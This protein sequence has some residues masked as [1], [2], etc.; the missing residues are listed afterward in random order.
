MTDNRTIGGGGVGGYNINWDEIDENTNPF[1]LG[2]AFRGNK[3][4]SSPPITSA[5]PG[6]A[7]ESA[8][9]SHPDLSVYPPESVEEGNSN[10][11]PEVVEASNSV[12]KN[13]KSET[14]KIKQNTRGLRPTPPVR[15]VSNTNSVD[16]SN[17]NVSGD[18]AQSAET[19]VS[20]NA[21]IPP[22]SNFSAKELVE[23]QFTHEGRSR[24]NSNSSAATFDLA[25]GNPSLLPEVESDVPL[26]VDEELASLRAD[27]EHLTTIVADMQ[28]CIAEYER[29]LRQL[30]EEKAR[31]E[32]SAKESVIDIIS[33][34]DQAVEEISTI[35][36]AF[37]DLH[38]RF[39]KSKQIIEGFKSNEE[40]L[41]RA[42][43]EYQDQL[44]RQEQR[45]QA[46]KVH[47]EQQL[48]KIAEETERAKR[49]N[50]DE[51]TR[52]RAA[53]KRSELRIHSLESQLEQKVRENTELTKI[54]DELLKLADEVE[55]R[56]APIDYVTSFEGCAS[57]CK[58][59]RHEKE[60]VIPLRIA[61]P[62]TLNLLHRKTIGRDNSADMSVGTLNSSS[63]A[64]S[65]AEDNEIS[66]A[67]A[68]VDPDYNQVPVEGFG[69]ALLKGM[70]L[71]EGDIKQRTSE[72]FAAKLRLKGL[73]LGADHR[74][75]LKSRQKTEVDSEKL[76]WKVGAKCQI[77]YGRNEGR[78]GVIKG[79][80][81][82]IG[83]IMVELAATKQIVNVMQ[84]T[85]RLVSSSEFE[86]F[87][88]YLNMAGAKQ[89]NVDEIANANRIK[90][91]G[92]VAVKPC[93][94]KR[95]KEDQSNR[96]SQSTWLRKG[97]IVRYLNKRSKY[98]LR[99]IKVL[100]VSASQSHSYQC[101]C[102][103]E[104]GRTLQNIYES[105]LKPT[106]PKHLGETV[107]V[108]RGQYLGKT[109]S[110]IERNDRSL[111]ARISLHATAE[112][113]S[114]HYAGLV[115]G[116][117]VVGIPWSPSIGLIESPRWAA[118][119]L[120]SISSFSHEHIE[121]FADPSGEVI[122][123]RQRDG[124]FVPS[125]KLL[126]K[127]PFLLPQ[128][129]IDRGAIKHV[130][131]GSNIMCPGLTSPGAKLCDVPANTVV[132]IMAEGKEH[133]VAVGVT[134]MSTNEMLDVNKNIGLTFSRMSNGSKACYS[135]CSL[136]PFKKYGLPVL[137]ASILI[138]TAWKIIQPDYKCANKTSYLNRKGVP[139]TFYIVNQ[140]DDY[141][142]NRGSLLNVGVRESEIM[143]SQHFESS[144]SERTQPQPA[145]S[146]LALHDVDLL[147]TD[148]DLRYIGGAIIIS[149]ESYKLINGFSNR[150]W[151]WGQEDDEFGLRIREANL[152]IQSERKPMVIT[153][154]FQHL[155]SA[156]YKR[157][158]GPYDAQMAY[159]RDHTSGLNTTQ[160][161]VLSR[162]SA[163]ISNVSAWILNVQLY[164]DT[165]TTPYCRR[166]A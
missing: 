156:T 145:C 159:L 139:H 78:Y 50:E 81:G 37:G 114:L 155:H 151:G 7:H 12:S 121:L 157:E 77:V 9:S 25:S 111:R 102:E 118:L 20:D 41:K 27:K 137:A 38:R 136:R 52:L 19:H 116:D 79:M 63:L 131:N 61:R 110:L 40:A 119:Y 32:E 142:F 2:A 3:L 166:D 99:K 13:T 123:F 91:Q 141:R 56:E 97:L 60:L 45:Y 148:E 165:L 129:Q 65:T 8:E 53:I 105:D 90:C 124:P 162:V 140:A 54:C 29:S 100:S 93:S 36:K 128:L 16:A 49:A 42:A 34:R 47:A 46:L 113:I 84:A 94:P 85:V 103:T 126:H 122:F 160:Y 70:G 24:R 76:L 80:D 98:Y 107:V 154:K 143:E 67:E 23:G 72:C 44:K 152:V 109:G 108:I 11:F 1:G 112:E 43:Q 120:T 28:R 73:G 35:E 149:R 64:P 147:P 15:T 95:K 4:A 161:T 21:D 135:V 33:E 71:K 163:E 83:R 62:D 30:A 5:A 127:Y 57:Q 92:E 153:P 101:S 130:L 69:L 10:K 164:C 125:L 39:E 158:R 66:V 26:S 6:N 144:M 146:M 74:V 55:S 86:N 58:S 82:D 31:A 87:G 14:A 51:V 22:P 59:D 89:Y 150:F 138:L 134:T 96:S 104:G 68:V 18:V 75:L 88:H 48:T 106:V 117:G 132:A 133:A 17:K 115:S